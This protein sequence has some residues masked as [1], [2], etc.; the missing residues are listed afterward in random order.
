MIHDGNKTTCGTPDSVLLGRLEPLL[1]M[2]GSHI[3]GTFF[4]I[5]GL[6]GPALLIHGMVL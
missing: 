3:S 6:K 5:D 1:Q 4:V 2:G